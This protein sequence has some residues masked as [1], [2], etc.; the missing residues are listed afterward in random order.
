MKSVLPRMDTEDSATKRFF[1]HPDAIRGDGPELIFCG[2]FDGHDVYRRLDVDLWVLVYGNSEE[3]VFS[4]PESRVYEWFA[5]IEDPNE[6]L[7]H[8][9]SMR[10]VYNA[11]R[12]FYSGVQDL[13]DKLRLVVANLPDEGHNGWCRRAVDVCSDAADLIEDLRKGV[14]L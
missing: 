3:C 10:A 8:W 13:I 9:G 14:G 12:S 6:N 7:G 5:N 11:K 2:H 1:E 4:I